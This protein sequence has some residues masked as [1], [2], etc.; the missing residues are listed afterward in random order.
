MTK[1]K[2]TREK[3]RK[4]FQRSERFGTCVSKVFTERR[5]F[6]FADERGALFVWI[7]NPDAFVP[8]VENVCQH[9]TPTE[10]GGVKKIN[11]ENVK[12]ALVPWYVMGNVTMA[13]HFNAFSERH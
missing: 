2:L 10:P 5:W 6:A 4:I 3:K 1:E 13:R 9:D 8:L 12:K 7:C 11:G